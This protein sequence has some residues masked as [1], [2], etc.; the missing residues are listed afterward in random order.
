MGIARPFGERYRNLGVGPGF[1]IRAPRLIRIFKKGSDG[2]QWEA[3][4]GVK[5]YRDL[6][7]WKLGIE[8]ADFTYRITERFPRREEY[9]LAGHMRK[10]AVSIPLNIAEGHSRQHTREYRQ[11]CFISLGSCA[12]LETQLVIA[13][14]RGFVSD[15][16]CG[17]L[18]EMLDHESRMLKRLTQSLSAM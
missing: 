12:E 4:V 9:G 5:S 7:V 8:I 1:H 10:S 2:G 11:H 17:A 3:L 16:D 15:G 14:R 6:E 13:G 18:A